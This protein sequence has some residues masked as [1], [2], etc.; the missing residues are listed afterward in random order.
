MRM[1]CEASQ[2]HSAE[3]EVTRPDLISRNIP[4]YSFLL[5]ILSRREKINEEKTPRRSGNRKL[6]W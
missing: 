1:E 2:L 3:I 4:L 6:S 5:S